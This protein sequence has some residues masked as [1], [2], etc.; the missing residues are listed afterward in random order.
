VVWDG[1]V[2]GAIPMGAGAMVVG[3]A[4]RMA[5]GIMVV[6][7]GVGTAATSPMGGIDLDVRARFTTPKRSLRLEIE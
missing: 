6:G 4:A 5:M 2:V 1:A 3:A 7:G